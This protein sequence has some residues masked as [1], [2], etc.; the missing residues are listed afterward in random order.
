VELDSPLVG[1]HRPMLQTTAIE[2]AS[3]LRR[4]RMPHRS[5]MVNEVR[6]RRNEMKSRRFLPD[7]AH[8]ATVTGLGSPYFREYTRAS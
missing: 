1:E 2:L 3:S 8:E 4:K 5:Q 7:F 6:F